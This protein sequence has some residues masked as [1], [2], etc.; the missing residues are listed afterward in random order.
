MPAGGG[1]GIAPP[2]GVETLNAEGRTPR[3]EERVPFTVHVGGGNAFRRRS[4]TPADTRFVFER[5][6]A[7]GR[8]LIQ[9]WRWD[10]RTPTHPFDAFRL[11]SI[12]LRSTDHQIGT[13][14]HIL[15]SARYRHLGAR[16]AQGTVAERGA[17]PCPCLRPARCNNMPGIHSLSSRR[18]PVF[19]GAVARDSRLV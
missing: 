3:P 10:R 5:V 18:R 7:G 8:R 16:T 9:W 12:R 6:P 14:T 13:R 11:A 1:R 4:Q 15:S 17:R 19:A 2:P